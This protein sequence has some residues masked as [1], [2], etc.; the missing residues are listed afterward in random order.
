MKFHRKI[1]K[2]VIG[3]VLIVA[4]VATIL[5]TGNTFTI[6]S[7]QSVNG[8]FD[9][10]WGAQEVGL[11]ADMHFGTF[12]MKA[13]DNPYISNASGQKL[14]YD[15]DTYYGNPQLDGIKMYIDNYN[16]GISYEIDPNAV[17]G[18]PIKGDEI[19]VRY[20]A[21]GHYNNFSKTYYM[22]KEKGT[23]SYQQLWSDFLAYAKLKFEANETF[24]GKYNVQMSESAP[25]VYAISKDE[26]GN[27]T[28]GA[29]SISNELNKYLVEFMAAKGA[30]EYKP[31]TGIDFSGMA[32]KNGAN[33]TVIRAGMA[34]VELDYSMLRDGFEESWVEQYIPFLMFSVSNYTVNFKIP[35]N[36]PTVEAF[37]ASI[38]P[39][40]EENPDLENSI[41]KDE[42]VRMT[43]TGDKTISNKLQYCLF[44]SDYTTN[45][46]EGMNRFVDVEE[47]DFISLFGKGLSGDYRYLYVRTKLDDP[48]SQYPSYRDSNIIKYKF[49]L[50]QEKA[51]GNITLSAETDSVD[52]GDE[53]LINNTNERATTFYTLDGSLPDFTLFMGDDKVEISKLEAGV[54]QEAD[55]L[56]YLELMEDYNYLKVN[57]FWYRCSKSVKRYTDPIEIGT[58]IRQQNRLFVRFR[59]VQSGYE[60]GEILSS[61]MAHKL[62]NQ[63]SAPVSDVKTSEATPAQIEMGSKLNFSSATVDSEIFYTTN[64]SEPVV[65]HGVDA[66]GNTVTQP[67]NE[68]TKKY[69][70]GK[71]LTITE[72]I[73]SHGS[74]LTFMVKAV[75]YEGI[76]RK[77]SDSSVVKFVYKVGE[78]LVAEKVSAIPATDDVNHVTVNPGDKIMLYSK[79]QGATIYYTTNGTEPVRKSDGSAGKNTKKYNASNGIKVPA[80]KN[81]T[82]FT[83]TA[84][85]YADG[86]A[87]SEVVRLI[88]KFPDAVS[89]PYA[90]PGSG[91]VNE[92]TNVELKSSTDGAVIYYELAT[93]D[94]T[95]KTPGQDSKVYDSANPIVIMG[96][97]TIKAIAVSNGISSTEKTFTYRVS[98]KLSAPT[99]SLQSGSVIASGT[100]L[101][102]TADDGATIHYTIDGSNPADKANVGSTILLEGTS[103]AIITVRTYASKEGFSDSEQATYS[104]SFSSYS[105]AIFADKES[106][107]IVRN[108]ESVK[109]NTDVSGGIIYYTTDGSMPTESSI[110]GDTIIIQGEA[111][112]DIT[113]KAAVIIPGT[114]R[115]AAA[116]VFTYTIMQKLQAP[117]SN[118]PSS[119]IF[120]REGQV[121]LSAPV[122]TIYYTTDGTQPTKGSSVY[123]DSITINRDMTIKA[124]AISDDAD[125]SEVSTFTYTF[126]GQVEMPTSSHE[127]GELLMDTEITLAC[128]TEG[129][130]IYYTTNGTDPNLDDMESLLTYS[131]P[132]TVSKAITLKVIA[133]KS[134]MRESGVLTVGYTVREPVV[135]EDRGGNSQAAMD[136]D[137]GR[138]MSRRTFSGENQGPSF[139][140][141]VLKNSTYGVIVASEFDVIPDETKL[142]VERTNASGSGS[143]TIKQ[144][145]GETYDFVSTYNIGLEVESEEVQPDGEIELGIP[146]DAEYENATIY[147][148]H[149]A[150]DGTIETYI[151]RRS[152]GMAYAKVSHLSQYSI[153]APKLKEEE[154]KNLVP[155][156]LAV[157]GA[158]VIIAVIITITVMQRRKYYDR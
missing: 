33:V 40:T 71:A 140:D 114:M 139:H 29:T 111:G 82:L 50:Y 101:T 129:A 30:V 154:T 60:F 92:Y 100:N 127:S 24:W 41:Y 108:G 73:A 42:A 77:M 62:K 150:D 55:S 7:N 34:R 125:S 86:Y 123:K 122:G 120:T 78:Q 61:T 84:V 155:I 26:T 65:V 81:E 96:K 37:S 112:S 9:F 2:K 35:L 102:L 97:T 94:E 46:V 119:A 74:T 45:E 89:P 126:A 157:T 83:I 43:F 131:G 72:D 47:G 39:V 5:L 144:Q 8:E 14:S 63:V 95:P 32:D 64:G 53:V 93:G 49:N 152:G 51:A 153:V 28:E 130:A 19:R 141:I 75:C 80:Q 58:E 128:G 20:H 124:I 158:V 105:E 13:P 135:E 15:K 85:A 99:P 115:T 117:Q 52:V 27:A 151:P 116:A 1:N 88:Y 23:Y 57:G 31:E 107:T 87:A 4:V 70:P 149:T 104:Y 17:K 25:F 138:L 91:V 12:S 90:T 121:T 11:D 133:T 109:L 132:I 38:E 118:A 113:I 18:K 67:G 148:V 54:D 98:D 76:Y 106:G 69:D 22:I 66:T 145:L 59:S 16:P 36:E 146:I 3:I 10:N 79:T 147:V 48:N 103:G 137:S 136:S 134:G 143:M 6:A 44:S 21:Y 56:S 110:R 68:L 156:I 142:N